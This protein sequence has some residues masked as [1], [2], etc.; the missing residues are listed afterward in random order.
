MQWKEGGKEMSDTTFMT[1]SHVGQPVLPTSWSNK[2]AREHDTK[3]LYRTD[4]MS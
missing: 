3:Y 1:G 4:S 2:K